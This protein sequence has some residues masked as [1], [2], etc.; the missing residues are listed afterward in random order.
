[1]SLQAEV[2]HLC[3]PCCAASNAGT[4]ESQ[5]EDFFMVNHGAKKFDSFGVLVS[6]SILKILYS[7]CLRRHEESCQD[8]DVLGE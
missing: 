1:M 6:F 7:R 3:L 8:D 4:V 2:S 5:D